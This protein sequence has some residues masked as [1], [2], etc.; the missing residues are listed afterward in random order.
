MRTESQVNPRQFQRHSPYDD[1]YIRRKFLVY[2]RSL[3]AMKAA[4]INNERFETAKNEIVERGSQI[5][6]TGSRQWRME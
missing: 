5:S 4:P 3:L 6:G 1:K 2:L